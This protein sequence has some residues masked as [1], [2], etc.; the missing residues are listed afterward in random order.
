[1]GKQEKK[2]LVK[3]MLFRRVEITMEDCEKL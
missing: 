3:T 1:M 2:I